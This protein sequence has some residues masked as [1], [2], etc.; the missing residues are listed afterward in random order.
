[1]AGVVG[2]TKSSYAELPVL[3]VTEATTAYYLNL[4]V[5]DRPGVLATVASLFAEHGVSIAGV[6][7]EGTGEEAAL[8][9]R[10]HPA[11]EAAHRATVEALRGE[12]AVRAIAG[13]MRVEGA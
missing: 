10:T 5:A 9:V 12:P 6:R 1:V 11:R 2:P 13:L 8:I 4:H 7:Q 3:P